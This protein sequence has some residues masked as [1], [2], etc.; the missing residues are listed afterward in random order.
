MSTAALVIS[1]RVRLPLSE[2]EVKAVRAQGPGGQH[3]NK[4]ATAVELRFDI[5]ASS[6]PDFYKNRLRRRGD[7]RIS[8]DGIVVIKAQTHRSRE[9]NREAAL[10]RLTRL[11]QNAG[12][13]QRRRIPTRPGRRAK[14]KRL[15]DKTR[16]GRLKALRAPLKP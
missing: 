10:E 9:R 2:V 7:R 5:E 1:Q 14:E 6:L 16:R 13:V 15:Q 3:V 8:A 4:S 11:I 12:A